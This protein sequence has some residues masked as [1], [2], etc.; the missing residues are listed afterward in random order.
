MSCIL[1]YF[2]NDTFIHS[3]KRRKD[4]LETQDVLLIFSLERE[5]TELVVQRIH[6]NS[7]K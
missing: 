4:S 3:H 6:Q 7:K 1:W 2:N 5:I